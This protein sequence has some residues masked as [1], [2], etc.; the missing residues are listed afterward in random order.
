MTMLWILIVTPMILCYGNNVCH[1]PDEEIGIFSSERACEIAAYRQHDITS[2]ACNPV[3]LK[4][5]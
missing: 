2:Y 4:G 3:N 1:V 5:E